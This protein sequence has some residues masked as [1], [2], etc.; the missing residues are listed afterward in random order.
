MVWW[1][2][3]NQEFLYLFII[4]VILLVLFIFLFV[5][6]FIFN[7]IDRRHD[8][9]I[10]KASN[11]IRIFVIN[12]KEDRVVYFD[13]NNVKKKTTTNLVGFYSNFHEN[14]VDKVK[15]WI[16]SICVTRSEVESFIEAD[17]IAGHGR[18]N[19]F[20]LLQLLKYDSVAGV[21]HVESH[22]MKYITPNNNPLKVKRGINYGVVDKATVQ[23]L[24]TTQKAAKGFTFAIRFYYI[25]PIVNASH[26]YET[27]ITMSMKDIIYPYANDPHHIRQ[28]IDNSSNQLLLFDLNISSTS[29]ALQLANSIEK[30]IKKAISLSSYS[31]SISFAIGVVNN[32]EFYQDFDGAVECVSQACIYAQQNDM[33]IYLYSRANS[34]HIFTTKKLEN[35]I[36]SLFKRNN[37]KYLYRP[38]VDVSREEILGYFQ[39][40]R[41]YDLPFSD[42]YEMQKYA[43]KV[44]KNRELFSLIAK[45]TIS[46]FISQ[47]GNTSNRLFLNVSLFDCEYVDSVI[48]QVKDYETVKI[49]LMFDEQE[50]CD[51]TENSDAVIASFLKLKEDGY[52]IALSL[53]DQ[54]LIIDPLMYSYFDYFIVGAS[55]VVEIKKSTRN[56]LGI[57]TLVEQLLKYHKPI[58]ATD[59]GGNQAIEI[60][61]KSGINLVSS[62]GISA[63]SEMLL[64]ID[65]KKLSRLHLLYDK[66]N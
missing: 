50:I 37:I 47:S 14:D 36:T 30:D 18:E 48:K 12:F 24:V 32:S 22:M 25:K 10:E 40:I 8:L 57:L 39:Y 7:Y 60:I 54:D 66:Y 20:S 55:M 3:T 16:Y 6:I 9:A 53:R 65:K 11:T 63:S 62:D 61:I 27:F 45:N 44:E 33:S 64:P 4:T 58:I 49:V 41:A 34:R 56:R 31:D 19:Y 42:F 21:V 1:D 17:I 26:R 5:S 59:L 35:Q 13:K 38:I 29:A 52:K 23:T 28:I 51:N 46:R 15:Q 43:I 2:F